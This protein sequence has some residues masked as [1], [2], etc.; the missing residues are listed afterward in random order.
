MGTSRTS[1]TGIC[2]RCVVAHFGSDGAEIEGAE[3][4]PAEEP[5]D[6]GNHPPFVPAYSIPEHVYEDMNGFSVWYD[7]RISLD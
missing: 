7:S 4:G 3:A 6:C 5:E 1:R 2:L